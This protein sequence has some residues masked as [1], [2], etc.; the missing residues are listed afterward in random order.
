MAKRKVQKTVRKKKVR[1]KVPRAKNA[2]VVFNSDMDPFWDGLLKSST[3]R[4]W[5]KKAFPN[6]TI[7]VVS[8]DMD[9]Y[10][11][12]IGI[13]DTKE[14]II[15]GIPIFQAAI[16]EYYRKKDRFYDGVFYPPDI[17]NAYHSIA[18]Y[19]GESTNIRAWVKK[20]FKGAVLDR[21]K[22]LKP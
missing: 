16:K 10:V 17:Y 7:S 1:N 6:G 9:H 5:A 4:R 2:F 19:K 14:N 15:K 20:L 18:G 13:N 21:K 22:V 3:I 8:D 12:N 11:Y